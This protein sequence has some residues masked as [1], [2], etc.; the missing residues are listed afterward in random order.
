MVPSWCVVKSRRL[1]QPGPTVGITCLRAASILR[2]SVPFYLPASPR[3]SVAAT[4]R[5]VYEK[6]NAAPRERHSYHARYTLMHTGVL[7]EIALSG[8]RVNLQSA[9]EIN[10]QINRDDF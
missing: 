4:L 1:T 2:D 8:R 6:V 3:P 7:M 10:Q 5:E 9:T